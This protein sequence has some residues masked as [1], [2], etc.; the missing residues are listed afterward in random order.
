MK[1]ILKALAVTAATL[2]L[3][4]GFMVVK[5]EKVHAADITAPGIN[6]S[7]SAMGG[8]VLLSTPG[9]ERYASIYAK[10]TGKLYVDA[11]ASSSNQ[12]GTSVYLGTYSGSFSQGSN[13]TSGYVSAGAEEDGIGGLDVKAGSTYYIAISSYSAAYLNVRAYIIPYATRSLSAGKMMVASGKKGSTLG[14]TA[15]FKIRPTKTGYIRVK[16]L[17]D[18]QSYSYGHVTLMN[19]KKRAISDKLTYNSDSSTSYVVFG[20]KKGT[21]YYLRVTDCFGKG[22]NYSIADYY[23]YAYGVKYTIS[24]ATYKTNTKK[25]RAITLKRKAKAKNMVRVATGRT[26]SQWYKFKVTKKRTTHIMV[27]A[28]AMKS[29]TAKVTLYYGK[30]KVGSSTVVNGK[31]NTFT[32]TYSTTYGKA[33]RGTYYVKITSNKKCSGAYKIRYVK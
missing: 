24:S 1:K 31:K 32:V 15:Y 19:A 22:P 10:A 4:A 12:Y 9:A 30:K 8:E 16:L 2:L 27:D 17:E 28:G 5:A 20:V 3:A 33:Q 14:P 25:S 29:G 13:T 6:Y 26:Q 18:G 11:V 23:P 21:T 7:T